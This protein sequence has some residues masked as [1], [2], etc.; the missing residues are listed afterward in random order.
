MKFALCITRE[1]NIIVTSYNKKRRLS[2]S[3]DFSSFSFKFERGF[4]PN[5]L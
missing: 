2:S 5:S 4:H 1:D 3:R